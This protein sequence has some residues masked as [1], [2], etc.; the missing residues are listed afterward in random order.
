MVGLGVKVQAL[1]ADVMAAEQHQRVRFY[2]VATQTAHVHGELRYFPL[3]LLN[4][5][6]KVLL[7]LDKFLFE[8]LL[9][10]K[11]GLLDLD[12]L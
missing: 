5:I 10:I 1:G 7:F 4:V 12:D 9:E 8:D 11:E 2:L 3:Q 6:M